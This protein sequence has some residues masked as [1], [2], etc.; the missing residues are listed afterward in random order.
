LRLILWHEHNLDTRRIDDA[1]YLV[2]GHGSSGSRLFCSLV[3][4]AT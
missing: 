4:T 1:H 3:A 2:V